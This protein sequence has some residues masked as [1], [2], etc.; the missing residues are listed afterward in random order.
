MNKQ[1]FISKRNNKVTYEPKH[2]CYQET[3]QGLS[4]SPADV[5]RATSRGL[6]VSSQINDSLFYDG[7]DNPSF[8]IPIESQRGV[9]VADVWQAQQSAKKRII[10]AAK[11]D[12]ELYG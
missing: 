8:D 10:S 6:A 3:K 7:D 4:M 9:D 1:L 12:K 2:E 11:K 5:A